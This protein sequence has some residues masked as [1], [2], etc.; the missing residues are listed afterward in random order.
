MS[1]LYKISEID[2]YIF[3]DGDKMKLT[4]RIPMTEK[5][6]PDTSKETIWVVE[7]YVETGENT[8][9]LTNQKKFDQN[10]KDKTM[11]EQAREEY[12]KHIQQDQELSPHRSCPDCHED[13]IGWVSDGQRCHRRID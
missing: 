5:L 11:Y 8:Y 7:Q 9:Q 13:C 2:E 1:S 6:E 4:K 12:D 10:T 3:Q